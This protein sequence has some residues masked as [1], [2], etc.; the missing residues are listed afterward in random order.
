MADFMSADCS[1][2]LSART[3]H[4]GLLA[5]WS[6]PTQRCRLAEAAPGAD[7]RSR[8]RRTMSRSTATPRRPGLILLDLTCVAA[9]QEIIEEGATPIGLDIC[10]S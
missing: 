6:A 1:G 7:V 2:P 9:R 4:G 5:R 3:D 8:T 10:S